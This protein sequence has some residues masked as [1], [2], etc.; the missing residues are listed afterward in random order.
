LPTLKA[1]LRPPVSIATLRERIA[2]LPADPL[3]PWRNYNNQQGHWDLW[4]SQYLTPGHYDRKVIRDDARY[5]YNRVVNPQLL[6]YLGWASG[7]ERAVRKRAEEALSP[8]WREQMSRASGAYRRIVP[9]EMIYDRLWPST[10]DDQSAAVGQGD[11]GSA[12]QPV[13]PV[14]QLA[15]AIQ[16]LPA[17]FRPTTGREPNSSRKDKWIAWLEAYRGGYECKL[18]RDDAAYVYNNIDDHEL[19]E[20]LA[21]AC[22]VSKDLRRR[23]VA[24]MAD[25]SGLRVESASMKFRKVIGWELIRHRLWPELA[26]KQRS[27]GE[28]R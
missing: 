14:A 24:K 25:T 17:D 10:A 15:D 20:Y 28:A 6:V 16:G 27:R 8:K 21:W 2:R 3:R 7:V 11:A 26:T 18:P 23:A 5:C 22:D 1:D 13:I 4:L 9:W 19:L 12:V